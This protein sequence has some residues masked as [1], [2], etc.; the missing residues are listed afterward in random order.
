[1]HAISIIPMPSC[2]HI[3]VRVRKWSVESLY[4]SEQRHS[5]K[6]EYG[7]GASLFGAKWCSTSRR[8][9][10]FRSALRGIVQGFLDFRKALSE[11]RM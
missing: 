2:R 3:L 10:Q 5:G 11:A 9:L 1:M 4:D 8:M 7:Y 6:L